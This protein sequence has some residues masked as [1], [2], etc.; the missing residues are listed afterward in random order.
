MSRTNYLKALLIINGAKPN[1]KW[2]VGAMSDSDEDIN[3]QKTEEKSETSELEELFTA[4][5]SANSSLMKLSMVIRNSP[6]R[7]D[8]LKAASRYYI[9]SRYDIGH[10]KEKHGAA[11]RSSDWLL[12]RLGKAITRRRQYLKYRE[13]HNSKLSRGWEKAP[14]ELEVA[15]ADA[16]EKPEETIASTKATTYVENEVFT[17]QGR[18]DTKSLFGSQTSYEPTDVIETVKE[19]TVPPPPI[20]A[21]EGVPF[22]FGEPFQC[23]YCYTEQ[24]VENKTAWKYGHDFFTLFLRWFGL[25]ADLK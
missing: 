8:Y 6:T 17:E 3:S 23:P 4:V 25:M 9:D 14:E 24:I 16:D 20:M 11:Q 19:L 5:K 7:D 13:D 18:I 22:E 2:K 15:V 21:F 1:D 12:E 10:V